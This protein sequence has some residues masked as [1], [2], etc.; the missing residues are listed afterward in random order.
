MS[1]LREH[2]E[3]LCLA[4]AMGLMDEPD[5][6]EWADHEIAQ[7]DA[8]P[9]ELIDIA[10]PKERPRI[11]LMQQLRSLPGSAN[12]VI[13]AHRAISL[14]RDKFQNNEIA[15]DHAVSSLSAYSSWANV[16]E[17]EKLDARII[18]HIFYEAKQ[19][20]HGTL[21]S[22]REELNGFLTAYSIDNH[23]N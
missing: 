23:T 9:I 22:V 19:G 1:S 6:I 20:I 17:S 18:E 12:F 11:A 10:L 14:L 16:S 13:A 5:I 21:D 8:P 4:L 2:G 3:Y 7:L 15:F